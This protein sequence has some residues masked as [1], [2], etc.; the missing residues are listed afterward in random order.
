MA[1]ELALERLGDIWRIIEIAKEMAPHLKNIMDDSAPTRERVEC[2]LH[3]LQ[4]GAKYTPTDLDDHVLILLVEHDLDDAAIDFIADLI[5]RFLKGE[6]VPP[7]NYSAT[8]GDQDSPIYLL[9]QLA[10]WIWETFFK[11]KQ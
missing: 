6:E 4:I 9:I 5:D 11:D 10:I 8:V 2:V 1:G 3:L 7:M